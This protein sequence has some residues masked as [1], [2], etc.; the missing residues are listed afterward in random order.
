MRDTNYLGHAFV[1]TVLA[2]AAL[3]FGIDMITM[4]DNPFQA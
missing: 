2:A 4:A 3:Y 1:L